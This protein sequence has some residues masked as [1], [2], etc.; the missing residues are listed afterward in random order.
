MQR[1]IMVQ[2]QQDYALVLVDGSTINCI[3]TSTTLT[4]T[5]FILM[6]D[7]FRE[8]RWHAEVWSTEK[9]LLNEHGQ[10]SSTQ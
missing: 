7:V 2:G 6:D 4:V 10:A 3:R 1:L 8:K 9:D 5:G